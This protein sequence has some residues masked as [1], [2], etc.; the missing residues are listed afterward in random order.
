[1]TTTTPRACRAPSR[2]VARVTS[3]G[4]DGEAF[5]LSAA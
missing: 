4:T 5:R 3:T 2:P 1:M